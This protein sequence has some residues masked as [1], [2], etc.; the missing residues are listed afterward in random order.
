MAQLTAEGL[1]IDR[2]PDILDNL[3]D[4]ARENINP[5]ISIRDDEFLGQDY[6]ILSLKLAEIQELIEAVNN[7]FNPYKAEGTNLDDIGTLLSIPRQAAA[8]SYT[9][10]QRFTESNGFVIPVGTILE[11]PITLDRFTTTSLITLSNLTCVKTELSVNQIL[12]STLYQVN[13]EDVAYTYT[14]D[15]DA[16]E[17]EIITGLKASIDATTPTAFTATL[18]TT[19]NYLVI[20]SVDSTT[21]KVTYEAYLEF[22]S[23]TGIGR[24]EAE[25]TG[26]LSAPS[27]SITKMVTST[28]VVTTNP[29]AYILGRD[30]ESDQDYR[31]R[32]LTTRNL[33][34]KATVEAIQ[35]NTS[36]V[37]GVTTSKV[38]EN[39]LNVADGDGRPAHSFETIIQGGQDSDIGDAIWDAK[40]AGIESHGNT[41]VNVTDKYGNPQIV[42]LTRPTTVNLA[43][44]IS[45][46]I[47]SETTFPTNGEDLIKDSVVNNTNDNTLGEDII[48]ISYFGG[49]I[50]AVG[51]LEVLTVEVQQIVNQGDTPNPANWQ[52]TKLSISESELAKTISTDII[53]Q[54]I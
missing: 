13:V 17:L 52:T 35:D 25:N 32:L 50:S 7:N 42:K 24:V 53:V 5:N 28:S 26:A 31:T 34:G 54:E 45:Y 41:T 16:T 21:L 30:K 4:S 38:I 36:V 43:F 10:T 33:S 11:N 9:T 6:K 51:Y 23:V 29:T 20:E 22:E 46:T 27:N 15:A 19:N 44:R 2:Q 12:N 8:K 49:I 14:S 48:P 37:A 47:H 3:K 39:I 1:Q 18:D 40:P